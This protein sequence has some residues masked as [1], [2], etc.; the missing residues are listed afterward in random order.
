MISLWVS[1]AVQ[2]GDAGCRVLVVAFLVLPLVLVTVASLPALLVLPL[3]KGGA[4]RAQRIV[5]QLV[6]WT[7]VLASRGVGR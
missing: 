2:L 7:D 3:L 4:T 6:S 5:G 1:R